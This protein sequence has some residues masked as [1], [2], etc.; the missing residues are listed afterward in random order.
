MIRKIL[1]FAAVI[2]GILLAFRYCEFKKDDNSQLDYSGLIQEQIVNVGKLVV[3]EGHFSEVITYKNQEKYLMDM[4]SFEK[5]ALIVVN[6]DVTISYD[7]HKMKYDIDEKNKTITIVSIPKEEIKISP[8]IKFYDV[9]QSQLN[10]F[11]GDDYNKIN[12]SVK[13]NLSKKIAK[14]TLKS[15]AKNR[16]ISELSKILILTK[17]MGWKLQ[18]EGQIIEQESDLKQD[19]KL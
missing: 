10:P 13:A 5:K 14:S 6:A 9:A 3:T 19:L 17:T 1:L 18:Y 4:I 15:N 12:A 11:T 2:V 16:L 7:L 8:D